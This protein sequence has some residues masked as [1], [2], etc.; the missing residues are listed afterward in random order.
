MKI[1]TLN[2]WGAPYAQHIMAR[3][4]AISTRIQHDQPDIILLQEVFLPAQVKALRES[5][6]ADWRYQHHFASGVIGSGLLTLSRYPI[7]DSAFHRF[8]LGGK[9]ER[10]MQG[11]YYAGKGIGMVRLE[12]PQG[13]LAVFNCHTHAQ[14]DYW[15]NDNEYAVYTETNLYEA[16]RFITTQSGDV[17]VVLG[18]DLNVNPTQPGY[19]LICT[20]GRLVDVYHHVHGI[21]ATTFST[22]NPYTKHDD[23]CL[24]YIMGR[25][26]VVDDIAVTMT[27]TLSDGSARAY[28]DHYGLLA[29]VHIE[30][31]A[32]IAPP[33]TNMTPVL[34]RL[35]ER[36]RVA[37]AEAENERNSH[38]ERAV[39]A[40]LGL[41]DMYVI[42]GLIGR[43]FAHLARLLR[44][45]VPALIIAYAVIEWI[46]GRVN[47]QG[48][49]NVLQATYDELDHHLQAADRS[50]TTH[51]TE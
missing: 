8:R 23:Q 27:E 31:G 7:V 10:L 43:W 25:G 18:G 21:H 17:P 35:Q 40:L 11:D 24:D 30:L 41:I 44:R 16:T 12:T 3:I 36:V 5:L 49:M 51:T 38:Y 6:Q 14:Y 29:S 22:E 46:Q 20:V 13:A 15:N 32:G 19:D 34:S 37:L 50:D 9:P 47:L 28:S 33:L 39:V 4:D 2:I 48:R 45:V 26:I 42:T 1:L